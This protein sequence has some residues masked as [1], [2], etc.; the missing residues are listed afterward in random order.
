[1]KRMFRPVVV[2]LFL[3]SLNA[4]G[5]E[6]NT[7]F[8]ITGEY[9]TPSSNDLSTE[10]SASE[11]DTTSTTDTEIG[12]L[13]AFVVV[14]REIT[15]DEGDT[16]VVELAKGQFDDGRVELSG[17]IEEL[18]TVNI[19]VSRDGGEES[20][21]V[22][23]LIVPGGETIEFAFVDHL[24]SHP[25]Q[26]LLYG[27]SR[28]AKHTHTKF[29]ID[30]TYELPANNAHSVLLTASITCD[31]YHVDGTPNQINFGT[32]LLRN[33]KY[34][35]DAD[36]K[37]PKV[38]TLTV[39]LGSRIVSA[40]YLVIE[41]NVEI[42]IRRQ[43]LN[44]LLI[45]TADEGRH[46]RLYNSWY[47]SEEYQSTIHKLRSMPRPKGE[48]EEKEED[49]LESID[50]STFDVISLVE[51][52]RGCEHVGAHEVA[53]TVSS[54]LG[55]PEELSERELLSR[56]L[57]KLREDALI[58]LAMNSGDSVDSLVALEL[59]MKFH[60]IYLGST[61]PDDVVSLYDKLADSL[62]DDV[63]ARRVRPPRDRIAKD[64]AR[65][66]NQKSLVPGQKAPAFSLDNLN[67]EQTSLNDVLKVNQIVL[68][69]FWASWCG[70]CIAAFPAWKELY[71]TH[72]DDGLEVISI[73]IDDAYEDWKD[74]S[75]KH[76]LPWIDLGE[77]KG[78]FGG[79]AVTYGID[80]LPTTFL[81]DSEGCILKKDIKSAEL[82]HLLADH[83]KDSSTKQ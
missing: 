32:V 73:S 60:I 22:L 44:N 29:S 47:T 49:D 2:V 17:E 41:P 10:V 56:K 15:N 50:T 53:Q 43:G 62:N 26:L 64:I 76:D 24:G 51:P 4:E 77:M 16:D 33:G 83:F 46:A 1:M 58:N 71:I 59:G 72:K 61:K 6:S 3:L 30:G 34:W 28:R 8:K 36:V 19:T 74:S 69:D 12:W 57:R 20:L 9:L 79:A 40:T 42:T 75:L 5:E 54:D 63:V 70:P 82:T 11:D 23:A 55:V 14:T 37:E 45:A 27:A 21:T 25:N 35:F 31:E 66:Y 65:S 18:A 81:V 13:T 48:P 78:Y 67:G 68:I 52:A 39:S 7:Q 38:A 80:A